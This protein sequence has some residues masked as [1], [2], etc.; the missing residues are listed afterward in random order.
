MG[1]IG[2]AIFFVVSYAIFAKKLLKSFEFK[3]QL[4]IVELF[5]FFL[6]LE[7]ISSHD[8]FDRLELR[9]I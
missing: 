2:L 7:F 9:E 5:L 1:S 6:H 3:L 4:E 8:A